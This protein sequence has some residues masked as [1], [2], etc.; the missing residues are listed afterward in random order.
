[1]IEENEVIKDLTEQATKE[2]INALVK[3]IENTFVIS[4]S[5]DA[6]IKNC[7]KLSDYIKN[8]NLTIGE[9]E[10]EKLL[11]V[12]PKLNEMFK[13]LYLADKLTK[14]YGYTNLISLLEIY[15]AINAVEVTK[16]TDEAVYTRQEG[17]D[18]DLVKL[19]LTEIGQYKILTPEEE[20]MIAST[21]QVDKL[22]EHN[23]RLVVSIAK[24]F[25]KVNG[26]AI[27]DL[28]Q[29]GNEGLITAAN[30]FD[31]KK[32]CRFTTYA[33]WWIKQAI[34]R[35]IADTSRAIRLPVQV[36]ET[37][38]KIKKVINDYEI[39]H[40]GKTPA[41]EELSKITGL[42]LDRIENAKANMAM[43]ISLS[44]PLQA[45]EPDETIG[46]IIED[47][48]N[49]TEEKFNEIFM[50]NIISKIIGSKFL[51]DKEKEVLK[52]R[53]GFYGKVYTLE[54]ISP[55]FK[56]TRERIRQIEA[57]ALRKAR[58]IVKDIDI[59]NLSGD[60]YPKQTE[61]IEEHVRTRSMYNL[62]I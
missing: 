56:V 23:L 37:I 8:K 22:I 6:Q 7:A 31:I 39:E 38:L 13:S 25:A 18:I 51:T 48:R 26:M 58:K 9:I 44:T 57:S 12:S 53:Y 45:E 34:Q 11:S 33:T 35:G 61:T 16:D 41:D 62:Y 5:S 29:F 55:I 36:H 52:Y 28:I 30:K 17:N 3:Y 15:C 4:D 24:R 14:I 32:E 49:N 47:A 21:N 27:G 59:S 43:A 50:K 40:G 54:E 2:E 10:S 1:M 42:S 19:Y 60:P 20:K 46:D